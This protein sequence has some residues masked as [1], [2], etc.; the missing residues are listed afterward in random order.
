M[1]EDEATM[2]KW[3]IG[4]LLILMFVQI[5]LLCWF[6]TQLDQMEAEAV[7]RGYGSFEKIE[8]TR[9]QWKDVEK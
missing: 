8:G 6:D 5:F 1:T 4:V 2:M 3:T 7:K 9:F